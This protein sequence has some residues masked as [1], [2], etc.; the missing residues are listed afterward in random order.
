MTS[1]TLPLG[2]PRDTSRDAA[3]VQFAAWQTMTGAERL[4]V[5]LELSTTV[6]DLALAG[7]RDRFPDEPTRALVRNGNSGMRLPF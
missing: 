5:A 2:E 4:G 7:L 3:E 1:Q 6:R